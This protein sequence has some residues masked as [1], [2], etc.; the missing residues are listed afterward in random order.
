MKTAAVI[1]VAAALLGEASAT[2]GGNKKYSTPANCDNKC[3]E[4]QKGGFKWDDMPVGKV[5]SYN[6][7]EFKGFTCETGFN[8]GKTITGSCGSQ[9]ESAP[10]IGCDGTTVEQFSIKTF[11]VKPEFDCDLE[12][13]FDM[14][15]GSN[16][17][18]RSTCSKYGTSVPNNQC[19]GAK[20]VSVVYPSQPDKPSGN[21]KVEIPEIS[22][23]CNGKT[24]AV[25]KTTSVPV[26]TS[27]S[28][29]SSVK[30]TSSLTTKVK[31]SSTTTPA[32]ETT[33]SNSP[34]KPSSSSE[35]TPSYGKE[36]T[37]TVVESSTITKT[38]ASLTTTTS[39]STST[40]YSTETSE[41]P[42]ETTSTKTSTTS[43]NGVVTKTSTSYGVETSAYTTEYMK[44]STIFTTQIK[45]I[46]SCAPTVTDCPAAEKTSVLV[47]TDTVILSTTICPVTETRVATTT[48]THAVPV[49]STVPTY[50]VTTV[51]SVGTT[52]STISKVVSSEVPVVSTGVST[53]IGYTT[54]VVSSSKLVSSSAPVPTSPAGP[55][56]DY[57]ELVPSCL[58]TWMDAVACSGN[59]DASCYCPNAEFIQ[60]V[61]D[62]IYSNG[63]NDDE[64]K[65]ALLLVQGICASHVGTNPCI[66]S[67]IDKIVPVLKV[68]EEP[69]L[70]VYATVTITATTVVPCE[71]TG[72]PSVPA[73]VPSVPAGTAP[74]GTAPAGTAPAGSVPAGSSTPGAYYP[75]PTSSVPDI[76]SYTT[77]TLTSTATIPVVDFHTNDDVVNLVPAPTNPAG[78]V[79]T[80]SY[81]IPVQSNSP[82]QP[83]VGNDYGVP[84]ESS[85]P[86]APGAPEA[87]AA[88][89]SGAAASSG[90]G[91]GPTGVPVTAGAS[92]MT[93]ASVAIAA[94]VAV[95]AAL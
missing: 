40:V 54:S 84:V 8:A 14:P 64:I 19:G 16:C 47:V 52:T 90:L 66:V 89:P 43:T 39:T 81:G 71:P 22:F 73:G 5:E 37:S 55:K 86:V 12:F 32:G 78:G 87:P 67:G 50:G 95:F 38:T 35:T 13:H 29:S 68:V 6:G 91:A 17:K 49:V 69:K 53:S 62:C 74:A 1:A 18:S 59:T 26:A 93:G 61:Y 27:T 94:L 79:Y 65:K 34:V 80:T 9:K 60:N 45:T 44:T 48:K 15:D 30:P 2:F 11:N 31:T 85:S 77:K 46:T 28:T 88:G 92:K 4:A 25:S 58:N 41:V 83:P 72:V 42:V 76:T 56:I 33:S 57:P 21:C 10:K 70:P 23:D 51:T 24:P 82:V 63:E 3:T 36:T 20:N 7:F 75:I